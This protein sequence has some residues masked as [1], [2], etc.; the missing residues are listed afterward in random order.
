MQQRFMLFGR[1]PHTFTRPG[2]LIRRLGPEMQF[3]LRNCIPD[4][5]QHNHSQI[6]FKR[7]LLNIVYLEL[8]RK[9]TSSGSVPNR[10]ALVGLWVRDSQSGKERPQ[11]VLLRD[12]SPDVFREAFIV[13][14]APGMI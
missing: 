5:M 3:P 2:G 8:I 10:S 7:F 6:L 4:S 13:A 1:L 12:E 14:V 11:G 9:P